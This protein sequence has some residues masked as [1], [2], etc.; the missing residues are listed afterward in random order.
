MPQPGDLIA[1]FS[2]QPGRCL[3]MVQA[4]SFRPRTARRARDLSTTRAKSVQRYETLRFVRGHSLT[5]T[6]PELAAEAD[7]W[8]PTT[9]SF[10][11]AKKLSWR[12]PEG[13]TPTRGLL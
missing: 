1:A 4:P 13:H 7:G 9:V 12:C 6:H 2:P 5:E 3:R 11:M 10:G 8:D